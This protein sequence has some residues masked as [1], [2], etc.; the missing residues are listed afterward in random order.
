MIAFDGNLGV[1]NLSDWVS[2]IATTVAVIITLFYSQRQA[3]RDDEARLHALY[4]WAEDTD[5]TE[6]PRWTIQVRNDTQ[7]PIYDWSVLV[8]TEDGHDLLEKKPPLNN[9]EGGVLTPGPT[10]FT[11]LPPGD[12]SGGE[13]DVHVT[14]RFRDSR[15]V[16]MTRSHTGQLSKG[17]G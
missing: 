1:G 6:S 13:S 5:G 11:W 15:G 2:G 17:W 9:T 3:H 8:A 4:A 14:V 12:F 7:Y 10:Y 16:A